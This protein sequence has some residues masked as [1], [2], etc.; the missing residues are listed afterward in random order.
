MI[1]QDG[2][3]KVYGSGVISSHR[4]CA[5]VIER[6]C[7]V[8]DFDLDEMLPPRSKTRLVQAAFRGPSFEQ[9]YQAM[10]EAEKQVAEI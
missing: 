8:R 2:K 10:E 6:G 5:N 9:L 7:E 1:R 3:I 4:E